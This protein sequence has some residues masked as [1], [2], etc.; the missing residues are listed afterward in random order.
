[1]TYTCIYSQN[2]HKHPHTH[3]HT[4][5][6][7]EIHAHAHAHTHT[8]THEN[9]HTRQ[10]SRAVVAAAPQHQTRFLKVTAPVSGLGAA[11]F[12]GPIYTHSHTHT[13]THLTHPF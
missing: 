9:R 8:H 1:N 13:H 6:K 2:T 7:T 4:H 5:M 11:R 10:L 3:T 12:S